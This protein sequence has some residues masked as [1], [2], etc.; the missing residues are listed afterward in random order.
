MSQ[1]EKIL[2]VSQQMLTLSE[3]DA[4]DAVVTAQQNRDQLLES[5]A[6]SGQVLTS[7][8]REVMEK[9]LVINEQVHSVANIEKERCLQSHTELNNGKTALNAYQLNEFH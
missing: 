2:L 8:D 7:S 4:W 1:L 3:E 6:K 5:Y 9:I